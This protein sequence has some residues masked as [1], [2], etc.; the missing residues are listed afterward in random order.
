MEH[1]KTFDFS[2]I[3]NLRMKRGL[4]AE[5][6]ATRSKMT[7][8]TVVKIESGKG[9]PTIETISA[10]GR[11]FQLSASQLIAMAETARVEKR[12]SAP[13]EKDGFKEF[14]LSF[15]NFAIYCLEAG[16]GVKSVSK[17]HLHENTAEVCLVLSGRLR[18]RVMD[19]TCELG[20][21][22]AI[23]FKALQSIAWKPLPN[24]NF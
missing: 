11:V 12:E 15:P 19:E 17:P 5:E 7:R 24:Q 8:A 13:F 2:I 9:N 18:V 4:T 14:H 6:L 1:N 22:M 16:T 20:P 10:L 3:R 21:R 23:R